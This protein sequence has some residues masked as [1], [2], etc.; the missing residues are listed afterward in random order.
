MSLYVIQKMRQNHDA[1]GKWQKQT[2]QSLWSY[3]FCGWDVLLEIELT[4]FRA[5]SQTA[6]YFPQVK[7]EE[8]YWVQP[9]ET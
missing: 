6:S 8:D 7:M 3:L 2:N 5:R 9:D 1:A 4:Y